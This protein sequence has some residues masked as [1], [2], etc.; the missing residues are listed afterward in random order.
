MYMQPDI[1]S[2]IDYRESELCRRC[3]KVT[4]YHIRD[5]GPFSVG[6][7]LTEDQK[8]FFCGDDIKLKRI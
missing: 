6:R 4:R 5:D 7:P 1:L 8:C 3:L 2:G